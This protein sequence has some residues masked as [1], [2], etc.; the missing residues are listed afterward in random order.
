M[1]AARDA[2]RRVEF[3]RIDQTGNVFL[4][5][6]RGEHVEHTPI[7]F[8]RQAGRY[9]PEYRAIRERSSFL[10]MCKTPD[11][12]VEITLQPVQHL[13]VDAAILFSDILIPIEKMG[14]PIEFNPGPVLPQPI[15]TRAQVEALRVPE[16]QESVPFVLEAVR[17]LRAELPRRVALIGFCGA[18]W[19]LANYAAEGGGSKEF[20]WLKRL[21]YE[22]PDSARQLLEKLAATNAAYLQAQVDAG[23]DA[24]QIF[25]TWAGIA[26]AD[27]LAIWVLPFV[28][29]IVQ[30]VR[31][32][33]DA[34]IIYFARNCMHAMDIVATAGADV[35]SVDWRTPLDTARRVFDRTVQGNLDPAALF[36]PWPVLQRKVE[37]VLVQAGQDRHVFNLGHG[38]LPGTPVDNVKR[39]VD[40]VHQTTRTPR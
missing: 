10:D 40:H 4:R 33:S 31:S 6:C 12:A 1:T 25:D 18:P 37:Q 8:M 5:A 19:T 27:D 29:Q 36:A 17:R 24:V 34:P 30:T 38:I 11:L 32:S 28:R 26:D 13:G 35:Y 22:D 39:V 15:R 3:P 21:I 14:I 23:A 7:W 16:P 9:M 20:T 2:G